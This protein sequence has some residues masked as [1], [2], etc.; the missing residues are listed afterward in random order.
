MRRVAPLIATLVAALS[1]SPHAGAEEL[2][3]DREAANGNEQI[4]VDEPA[5]PEAFL[6]DRVRVWTNTFVAPSTDFGDQHLELTRHE[7]RIRARVPVGNQLSVQVTGDFRASLYDEDGNGALFD[8]CAQCSAPDDLYATSLGVQGGYLLNRRWAVFRADELWALLGGVYASARFEPGAFEESVSPGMSFGI[9]YQLP[10]VVRIAI[11]GRVERALD[12]DGVKIAP[13]GYLRWKL[14]PR[15]ELRNRGLG[16]QLEYRPVQRWE[17]FLAGFRSSD[18]FRL[19]DRPNA[20]SGTTFKDSQ[21]LVGGGVA[22][23]AYRAL[24]LTFEAGAI[25]DREISIDSRNDGELD[26]ADG[27]TSPY[28]A[29]RLELRP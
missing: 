12:G 19:D 21:I 20:P 9:G 29:L 22:L 1:V 3:K 16:L 25:V 13:T 6:R 24:R 18:S 11:A 8:D 15:L 14:A 10:D 27:E 7:F 4:A 26:S 17:F 2:S 23:K 5:F 28:F